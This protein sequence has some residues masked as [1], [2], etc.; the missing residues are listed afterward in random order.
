[1][2]TIAAT[3]CMALEGARKGA[4]ILK[5][6]GNGAD[7]LEAL[8]ADVENDPCFT[9][10]GYG[11]LPD[12]EG[13]LRLDAGYMDGTKMVTGSVMAV[14][15]F[16]SPFRIARSLSAYKT[17]TV[18]CAEGAERYA[19]EHGF[20]EKEMR[21]E[22]SQQRWKD[23]LEQDTQSAYRGH[24]TV[25]AIALDEEGNIYAG[26]STSGLFLKKP[27]RVGDSPLIGSGFYADSEAG[28]AVA[29]GLGE[30]LMKGCISYETVRLMKEGLSPQEAC[31]RAVSELAE[32]L[33]R[34]GSEP[35]DLSVVAVSKDGHTGASSNI[36]GFSFVFADCDHEPEVYLVR[37]EGHCSIYEKAPEEWIRDYMMRHNKR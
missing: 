3:W 20:E 22:S 12:A 27:F 33:I 21:T 34:A 7:A 4:E 31:D 26:T 29:T 25:G 11:G 37:K 17:N 15:G 35:G 14:E 24:D 5:E 32:R 16:A 18:L 28:A 13:Y 10:V 2:W 36:S 1:M 30:D 19:R 9:S 8:I 6:G 23:S